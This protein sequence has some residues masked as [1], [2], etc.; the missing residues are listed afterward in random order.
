MEKAIG[1]ALATV[2]GIVGV[3][4]LVA[5]QSLWSGYVLHVLWAWFIVPTFG[6][7]PLTI[8][9]AIG[10]MTVLGAMQGARRYKKDD[11]FGK[12]IALSFMAPL[13]SLGV[14]FIVRLYL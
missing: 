10:L 4:A 2:L 13:L 8:A 3:V 6:A 11:E 12:T 9:A 14:G 5:L 7:P 1:Y